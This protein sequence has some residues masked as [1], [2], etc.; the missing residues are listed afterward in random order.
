MGLFQCQKCGAVENSAC[1][2]GYHPLNCLSFT[3]PKSPRHADDLEALAGFRKTLGLPEG[4][5][6]GVYCSV[7]TPVW[8][9]GGRYGVG[10]NPNP[11][12]G[13][14]L[15]HGRFKMQF[16]PKGQ[17]E[18]GPRGDLQHKRTRQPPKE[19]DYSDVELP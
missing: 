19:S 10:R 6:L 14:G 15:W 17:Y 4:A 13:A 16:L 18:T 11:T 2:S 5:K 8:Y 3:T 7:C 1:S 9:D 12:E